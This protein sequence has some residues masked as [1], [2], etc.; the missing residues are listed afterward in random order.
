MII[1]LI[2]IAVASLVSAPIVLPKLKSV[3]DP[4]ITL[5]K[6]ADQST[7]EISVKPEEIFE[8]LEDR[9]DFLADN[10]QLSLG[11]VIGEALKRESLESNQIEVPRARASSTASMGD[12]LEAHKSN[13]S[14][15]V[16]LVEVKWKTSK[17]L[18]IAQLPKPV[19]RQARSQPISIDSVEQM[20]STPSPD[21]L[22]VSSNTSSSQKVEPPPRLITPME[23]VSRPRAARAAHAEPKFS[24]LVEETVSHLRSP[25]N[26]PLQSEVHHIGRRKTKVKEVASERKRP[27][28]LPIAMTEAPSGLLDDRHFEV[29]QPNKKRESA[30][31]FSL[32]ES[33]EMVATGERSW[34]GVQPLYIDFSPFFSLDS[35]IEI[36]PEQRA[37]RRRIER[38]MPRG[39]FYSARR[40]RR[41]LRSASPSRRGTRWVSQNELGDQ[42][43][44]Q[45]AQNFVNRENNPPLAQG[46]VMFLQDQGKPSM[47]GLSHTSHLFEDEWDE[48]WDSDRE[49]SW[50]DE[51]DHR[52]AKEDW[53][54]ND[55]DDTSMA[56]QNVPEWQFLLGSSNAFL[57]NLKL[58]QKSGEAHQRLTEQGLEDSLA[59]QISNRLGASQVKLKK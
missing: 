42:L 23:R 18:A 59:F 13:I 38:N 20:R 48:E 32:N 37:L 4:R 52:D 19:A 50:D 33:P 8:D 10:D 51:D 45:L 53:S 31:R 40:N 43:A 27:A 16:P 14:E 28:V 26:E 35:L 7:D 44:N 24:P 11:F 25:E 1:T 36:T 56:S 21:H 9:A 57:F 30:R 2:A 15:P 29:I 5:R 55:Q 46:G 49:E 39:A 41:S 3:L 34:Y 6:K 54:W 22:F 12:Q 17:P 58:G 47:T